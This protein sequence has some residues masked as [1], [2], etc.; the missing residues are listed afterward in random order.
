MAAPV[1]A[2]CVSEPQTWSVLLQNGTH[3]AQ[4]WT[5]EVTLL[6]CVHVYY[7]TER[8]CGAFNFNLNSYFYLAQVSLVCVTDHCDMFMCQY[9]L[10][11]YRHCFQE[12]SGIM[13]EST[14]YQILNSSGVS[15]IAWSG[16]NGIYIFVATVV[17]KQYR[18]M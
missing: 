2:G 9:L 8:F 15:S 10:Q 13:G 4:A 6:H 12:G 7:G 14:P 16:H 11:N 1:Q 5:S 17:A 18:Y 3:P